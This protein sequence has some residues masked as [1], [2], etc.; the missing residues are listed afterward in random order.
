MTEAVHPAQLL[1]TDKHPLTAVM[2]MKFHA[3]DGKTLR[4]EVNAPESFA[5][6]DESFVHPGFHTLFLDTVM[7]SA[8]IG[9]L[10]KAQPIATVKLSCNHLKPAKIDE[11]II[12]TATVDGEENSIAYVTGN[13]R[14]METDELLSTAIATFMIGTASKPLKVNS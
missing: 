6:T 9:E 3:A 2:N 8:A 4:V 12:C 13:I 10:K 5:D 14:S 11:R 1:F 7:G